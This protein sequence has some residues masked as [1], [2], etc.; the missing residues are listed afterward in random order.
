MYRSIRRTSPG[1]RG[2]RRSLSP[3]P[4][5][6]RKVLRSRRTMLSGVSVHSSPNAHP[7]IRQKSDHELRSTVSFMKGFSDGRQPAAKLTMPAATA[8]RTS[9]DELEDA[10]E[11]GQPRAPAAGRGLRLGVPDIYGH[12]VSVP[13][14]V[15]CSKLHRRYAVARVREAP[16]LRATRWGSSSPHP[17]TGTRS[18]PAL[19][20]GGVDNS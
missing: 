17:G 18:V 8:S 15:L 16:R 7:L 20:G 9:S 4:V 1:V 3:L 6:F 10:A 11:E 12:C 19:P 2:A 13:G 14:W 5:T